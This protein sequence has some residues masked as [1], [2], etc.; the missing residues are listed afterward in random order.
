MRYDRVFIPYGAYWSSPFC[1]W[2]GSFAGL[3]PLQLAAEVASQSLTKSAIPASVLDGLVLGTT[4]PSPHGFYGGPWLTGLLGAG[5]VT[6]TVVSQACATSARALAVAAG[7]VET[8]ADRCVLVI[9][10][11]RTSNGPHLVW[12]NAGPGAR[13]LAEDWVWD[14]FGFD[15]S[16][17]GTMLQTAENVAREAGITTVE[18]HEVVLLRYAQYLDSLAD[19]R[20]FQR[21]YMP[22]PLEVSGNGRRSITV[23]GDEG[24]HP[25]TVDGLNQLKPVMPGGTVTAGGQTHPA[26]GNAGAV[27]TTASRAAELSHD[28]IT[29][30][31]VSYAEA[32]AKPGYMPQAIVPAAVRALAEADVKAGDLT[33]VTTHNPF[34]VNDIY[35]SRALGLDLTAMNRFGSSLVWGHPQAPTGLRSVIELIETLAMSGGGY[36]LFVGCSAG[37][38]AAALVLKVE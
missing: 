15:P 2:Q 33:A 22:I 3:H 32:R 12:P 35:L 19:D 20:A 18:Q 7:E 30:Q 10:A 36:G 17:G 37:D 6:G 34:A 13:P 14:N 16:T 31:L 11:D 1:R 9:A 21:R 38:S 24:I 26:D 27:V 23:E 8:A 29:V 28:G 4:V 25:T 5:E